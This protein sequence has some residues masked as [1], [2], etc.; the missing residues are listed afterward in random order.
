MSINRVFLLGRLGKDPEIRYTAQQM[1]VGNFTLATGDRRKDASGNWVEQ[2]EWHNIVVWG[3]TAENC[4]KYIKKGREVFIEGRI[5]TRKWQDK[6][7]RDRYTT[8]IVGLNVQFVGGRAE[9]GAGSGAPA[10][11]GMG[12]SDMGGQD[13]GGFSGA[14]EMSQT[15]P[16]GKPTPMAAA[17]M[18][19]NGAPAEV[20]FDEDDIPF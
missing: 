6:E 12:D 3:K 20:A 14:P 9:S 18:V 2:T 4:H 1:P 13:S 11:S 17:P 19:G 8:E 7:G 16:A 15:S 5:Q 10:G